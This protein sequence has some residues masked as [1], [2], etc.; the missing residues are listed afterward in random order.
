MDYAKY[1]LKKENIELKKYQ[2]FSKLF[3]ML[4]NQQSINNICDKAFD[5]IKELKGD[6]ALVQVSKDRN[7]DLI[8]YSGNEAD[9][10]E[11]VFVH[12][13]IIKELRKNE[14]PLFKEKD[15]D[16]FYMALPIISKGKFLG[17]LILFEEQEIKCWEELYT[18]IHF[19][20]F[21]FKY[22]TMAEENKNHVIKDSLTNL[23]NYRHFQDQMDLELE[24]ANRYHIPLTLVLV[25]IKNFRLIN[26]RLGFDVGD[27]ILKEVAKII[28]K[29]CR[30]IDMPSRVEADT[31][32]IL[33]SNTPEKGAYVLLNRLLLNFN[34]KAFEINKQKLKIVTKSSVVP[35]EGH[36]SG[37][38]FLETGIKGL[39]EISLQEIRK[40]IEN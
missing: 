5:L 13:D 12:A 31:F 21:V 10:E 27:E 33:L 38:D 4:N 40:K 15:D 37:H 23:F 9:V 25:D 28:D 6:V 30:K 8:S 26:E 24:K 17:A 35:Y 22:Y 2:L 32:A 18:V 7:F 19:F 14:K 11:K 16:V 39:K 36:I 34:R 1:L 3:E 20:S 29:N